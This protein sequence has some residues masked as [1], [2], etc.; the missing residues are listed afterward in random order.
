LTASKATV[1][2]TAVKLTAIVV[3]L[4]SGTLPT[5]A[6]ESEGPDP[7]HWSTHWR[8]HKAACAAKA[9][10]RAAAA[11]AGAGAAASQHA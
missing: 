6:D 10:E 8:A 3:K 1:N 11:E 5:H 2:L 7:R 9:A 4:T